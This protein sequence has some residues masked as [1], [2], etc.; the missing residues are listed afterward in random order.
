MNGPKTTPKDF[1]LYL[2]MV[3]TLYV[4]AVSLITLWFEYINRLLPS[5]VDTYVDPYSGAIRWSMAMLIIIF[6][7]FIVLTRMVNQSVRREPAKKELWIRRWLIYLTLF[8]AGATVAVDLV[9]LVNTFL[10]GEITGRFA[11]KVFVVFVVALSV[12]GYYLLSIRG[13]WDT[14]EATS[15]LFGWVVGVV[16]L[17][18]IIGGFFIIGSPATQRAL[19]LDQERVYN[20]Q[21]IQW[22]IVDYWQSKETLPAELALLEDSIRGFRVPA[23][24]ETGGP[25]RYAVTGMYSFELCATFVRASAETPKGVPSTLPYRDGG[26]DENW[27]HDAGETCFTRTIDPELYPPYTE[28]VIR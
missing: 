21:N 18:S 1:F 28:S 12:F 27:E 2:G 3:V 13:Y 24:P 8:I 17:G 15:K 22:Q 26:L 23:D 6:P 11:A 10:G 25:Y 14:R 20:L 16:A 5:V 9:A 4:S 7:L 19:R